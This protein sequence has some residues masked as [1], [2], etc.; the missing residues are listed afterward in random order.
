MSY[1]P[2]TGARCSCRRGIQ[3]DNCPACEGTGYTIDFARIH[4][5]RLAREAAN[6]KPQQEG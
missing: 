3:R 5:E 4:R 2:K 6:A 1:Q